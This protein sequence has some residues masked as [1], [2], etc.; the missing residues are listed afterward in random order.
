MIFF[1]ILSSIQPTRMADMLSVSS[2]YAYYNG[3]SFPMTLSLFK[4][5]YSEM[6]KFYDTY[7]DE[8]IVSML[9]IIED[10]CIQNEKKHGGKSFDLEEVAEDYQA[11]MNLQQP[12]TANMIL[13]MWYCGIKYLINHKIVPNDNNN[14]F[15]IH[16]FKEKDKD[17]ILV[18]NQCA[19]LNPAF[20]SCSICSSVYYC[21]IFCQKQ[22]WKEH[23]KV[24][25]NKD[26]KR[27]ERVK[28]DYD[29]VIQQ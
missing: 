5:N 26:T 3:T 10:L 20:K 25:Q 15:L 12:I 7:A 29:V 24:C 28:V 27:K 17:T 22:D 1:I 9:N 13:S 18:S 14:G 11:K 16:H 21:S 23:K 6:D 2:V 8:D 4:R 19:C